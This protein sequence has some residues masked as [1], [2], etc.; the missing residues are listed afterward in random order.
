[1]PY[2]PIFD[3][4]PNEP[5][6]MDVVKAWNKETF[7]NA[8]FAFPKKGHAPAQQIKDLINNKEITPFTTVAEIKKE[9]KE[10]EV[11]KKEPSVKQLVARAK[12]AKMAK[13]RKKKTEEK[14]KSVKDTI[15]SIMTDSVVIP[16]KEFKK[17]HKELV[18]V[19]KEGTKEE[20]KKEAK[21]QEEEAKKQEESKSSLSF[22]STVSEQVENILKA[23]LD[24]YLG[25][26]VERKKQAVRKALEI[27][28]YK[29]NEIIQEARKPLQ[30]K[31]AKALNDIKNKPKTV[32]YGI[33]GHS[34]KTGRPESIPIDNTE[35]AKEIPVFEKS[36][37]E[38]VEE[39]VKK[40]EKQQKKM[41]KEMEE[42]NKKE[43][44]EQDKK[45]KEYASTVDTQALKEKWGSG[46]SKKYP[47]NN[48]FFTMAERGIRHSLD[49][50]KN[51]GDLPPYKDFFAT[52]G[53]TFFAK[54]DDYLQELYE[55]DKKLRKQAEA[56]KQ[57][58]E[59][60]K[61]EE[62][63]TGI[64]EYIVKKY[65]QKV[66]E[67]EELSAL[68]EKQKKGEYKGSL[69]ALSNKPPPLMEQKKELERKAKN[70]E[71]TIRLQNILDR[72]DLKGVRGILS[73][74]AEQ[75]VMG[76]IASNYGVDFPEIDYT[77]N[78]SGAKFKK[79]VEAYVSTHTD[80]IEADI[81]KRL[82]DK[83]YHS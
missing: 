67:Y 40:E 34:P 37:V 72:S 2:K 47:S 15:K 4:L 83:Y 14:E 70:F 11:K 61:Q 23:L 56:K 73:Q 75:M 77:K 81:L 43:Q 33:L 82:F 20:Q 18:E 27:L 28:R 63:T 7:G 46:V 59:A 12:F 62:D 1:M 35:I 78:K 32:K 68:K 55:G 24:P 9:V 38:M 21:K 79:E 13:D 26:S 39:E 76:D 80:R 64:S 31:L 65:N 5:T 30:A 58:E 54:Y 60:K 16:E 74:Y 50:D 22:G 53:N 19:L 17:E 29:E 52:F 42:E 45:D 41:L 25:G 10:K 3:N 57:E 51:K 69:P 48:L 8:L 36:V 66:K 6:Y 49:Y 71:Y 44:E